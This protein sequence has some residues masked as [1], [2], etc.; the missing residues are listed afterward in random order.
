M[1]HFCTPFQIAPHCETYF[2]CTPSQNHTSLWNVASFASY[3]RIA[4]Y[5]GVLNSRKAASIFSWIKADTIAGYR[6]SGKWHPFLMEVSLTGLKKFTFQKS[7]I[8]FFLE[9]KLNRLRSITFSGKRHPYFMGVSLTGLR[10]I[11][12]QKCSVHF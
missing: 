8:Q 1:Q 7:D 9:F 3:A 4:P 11:T 5:Y 2:L 6:L 10:S 12:F